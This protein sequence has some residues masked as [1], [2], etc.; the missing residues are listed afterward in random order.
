MRGAR[1]GAGRACLF[2]PGDGSYLD[3]MG[4]VVVGVHLICSRV[5]PLASMRTT[6]T[7]VEK[8]LCPSRR[9]E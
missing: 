7:C 4:T 3:C 2:T 8:S 9:A 1:R 6:E 5:L